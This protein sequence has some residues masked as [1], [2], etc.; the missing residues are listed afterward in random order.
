MLKKLKRRFARVLIF[1]PLLILISCSDKENPGPIEE[2]S[3][4]GVFQTPSGSATIEGELFLPTG[5][6][7]FPSMVIVPGS[8]NEG[9]EVF[10]PLVD[11]IVE[12]G[13]AIYI[14]DKRGI[15]G[16]TGSYPTETPETVE[17][18]L[19]ARAD[20]IVG[21]LELLESHVDIENNRIGVLGSSQGAWVN[22]LVFR[23]SSALDYIIMASGGVAPTG[24][25]RLYCSL[26]D[27]PNITI[28]SATA[29]LYNYTGPLG[30]DPR[31]IINTMTLPVLWIYGNEDRSH[32]VRYDIEMLNNTLQK[33][34]FTLLVYLNTDHELLDVNTRMFPDKFFDNIGDWLMDNN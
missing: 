9:R 19:E 14:Y 20:D 15:G 3:G 21:I 5:P 22:S 24:I 7:P 30:F 17:V 27:D 33:P 12:Q 1:V 2:I 13:Y 11:I 10:L 18:F 25:E 8:G 28:D 31:P 16:S 6:G 29:E 32:P 26:T 4:P 34:N 23:K